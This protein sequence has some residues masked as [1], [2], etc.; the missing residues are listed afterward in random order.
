[1]F[2]LAIL[3]P[4]ATSYSFSGS[5][6]DSHDCLHKWHSDIFNRDVV[7]S[8]E[9]KKISENKLA[10]WDAWPFDNK[11]G[12]LYSF[13]RRRQ[14]LCSTGV[15]KRVGFHFTKENLHSGTAAFAGFCIKFFTTLMTQKFSK[16]IEGKF[17]CAYSLDKKIIFCTYCTK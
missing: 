17:G 15:M 10:A 3:L 2:L 4:L 8:A 9:L 7:E 16:K 14:P 5:C 13:N 11:N 1:L 6:T 12:N